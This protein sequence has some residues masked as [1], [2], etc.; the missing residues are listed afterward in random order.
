[1]RCLCAV[2]FPCFGPFGPWPPRIGWSSYRCRW[3]LWQRPTRR[4]YTIVLTVSWVMCAEEI[5]RIPAAHHR[6]SSFRPRT[7]V[8]VNA[9]SCARSC[10]AK[11]VAAVC[12]ENVGRA[13]WKPPAFGALTRRCKDTG[14]PPDFSF[15]DFRALQSLQCG[16]EILLPESLHPQSVDKQW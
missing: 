3:Q 12:L 11:Q 2:S 9:R 6:S 16:K 7:K 4:W 13:G 5:R 10:R 15:V 1:M 14:S 8:F